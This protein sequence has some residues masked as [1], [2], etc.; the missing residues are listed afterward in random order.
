MVR[1]VGKVASAAAVAAALLL[2]PAALPAAA[3]PILPVSIPVAHADPCP[4]VEVVFARGRV[5]PP[6]TGRIGEALIDAVRARTDKNVGYYAVNYPADTE[7]I[8][9]ANDMSRHIQ[10]MAANCPDTRL[11]L[12]GY[13]L[14]A[15]VT[16]VVLAAPSAMLGYTNPL[17][18]GMNDHIAAVA[19]FGNGTRA[20]F[21]PVSD[22]S[23]LYGEKT[24][25]LCTESDPICSGNLNPDDPIGDFVG[26]WSSHLQPAYI[27]SGLVDQAAD[28][29]VARL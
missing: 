26:S 19:L 13:S 20:I 6:G 10:Y 17:P 23:P 25:D 29:I 3:G 21:G 18:L 7:V 14:G 28:F 22:V 11:V 24:I 4:Q 16:D 12:G 15:A 1:Q 5:E 2:A 27:D 9:G 8:Q